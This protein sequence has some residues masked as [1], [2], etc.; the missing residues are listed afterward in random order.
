MRGR[1]SIWRRLAAGSV[2]IAIAGLVA[3][4]VGASPKRAAA[5]DILIGNIS[6]I[7]SPVIQ[8]T[9]L[10]NA[11]KAWIDYIN[12]KGGVQGR[13][14]K[15]VICDDQGSASLSIQCAQNLISQGVVGFA[16]MW[17][18]VFGANALSTV[19]KANTAIMGGWP[20][21]DQEYASPVEFPVTAGA[22][23]AY[24]ALA[25][26][27]RSLGVKDLAGM[28]LNTP[29]AISS[30]ALVQTVWD[31]LAG[32]GKYT[33]VYY[34]PTA[35]DY[36]PIAAT[37]V[38]TGAQGLFL[39]TPASTAVRLLQA[40]KNTGYNG[41]FGMTGIA[42]VPSVLKAGGKDLAGA[43]LTFPG[44]PVTGKRTAQLKLFHAV[45]AKNKVPADPL[46]LTGAAG[47]QYLWDV[48]K[49]IKGP[50]TRESV[51]AAA[52]KKTTWPGFLTH[53]MSPKF[54]PA[55]YPAIRNPYQVVVRYLGGGAFIKTKIV[56]Y[57]RY[58]NTENGTFY[59]SGF[60]R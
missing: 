20:I 12:S 35:A 33:P 5:D 59:I 57:P 19:E 25:V 26:T 24:P 23:G 2:V 29:A 17:S 32:A 36:T 53:S 7:N 37:A 10:V 8:A 56:G 31:G 21:T 13:K 4:S 18:I 14:I 54:A 51:L 30:S 45:M 22:A 43:Y 58:T 44:V 49:S 6:T 27:M 42:A 47:G 38:G 41:K 60:A 34:A 55:Q 3:G 16:G 52:K 28:W 39:G 40:L 15:L 9:D 48:L 46:S 11:T 1:A 50:I